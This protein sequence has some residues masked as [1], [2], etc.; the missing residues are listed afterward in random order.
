MNQTMLYPPEKYHC[1]SCHGSKI[2]FLINN[3]DY[4]VIFQINSGKA[5]LEKLED[6]INYKD[7]PIWQCKGCF[8]IGVYDFD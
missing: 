4:S 2:G 3:T 8:D 1:V 7:Y 5:K 6:P